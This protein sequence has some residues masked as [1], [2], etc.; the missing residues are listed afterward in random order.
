M[1]KVRGVSRACANTSNTA[2]GAG[3]RPVDPTGVGENVGTVALL[4]CVLEKGTGGTNMG[5]EGS[6]DQYKVMQLKLAPT[7]KTQLLAT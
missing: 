6:G 7:K 5:Q 1:R 2:K 3:H 4:Y